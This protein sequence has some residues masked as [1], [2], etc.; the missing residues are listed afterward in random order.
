M[1]HPELQKGFNEGFEEIVMHIL[2]ADDETTR[3]VQEV[4]LRLCLR[5]RQ[6][7]DQSE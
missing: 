7:I 6:A 5:W 1:M 4:R 2:S 3:E